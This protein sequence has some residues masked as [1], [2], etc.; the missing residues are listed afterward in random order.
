[1]EGIN[2]SMIFV[3]QCKKPYKC[4]NASPKEKIEEKRKCYE[5]AYSS[6]LIQYNA[7]FPTQRNEHEKEIN[8]MQ[9]ENEEI[10]V[11]LFS[12]DMIIYFK[13]MKAP[14]KTSYI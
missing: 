8:M 4:H 2:S 12:D 5:D 9:I 6:T 13:T 3:I 10:E 11:S 14:P 1:V 7:G